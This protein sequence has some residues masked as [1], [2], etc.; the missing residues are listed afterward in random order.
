M[1][2]SVFSRPFDGLR[3]GERFESRGRTVT[4]AHVVAFAAF[5]GDWHPV[6]S[7]AVWAGSSEFGGRIA[8][9]LLV[10]SL[11]I[12]MLELD[13]AWVVALRRISKA[14]FKAPVRLGDTIHVEGSVVALRPVGRD[15]GLVDT[16]WRIVNQEGRAVAVFSAEVV[17]RGE[18]V[19]AGR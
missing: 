10:L 16:A 7:D 13:P 3:V 8:H 18:G 2:T 17:W 5:T 19:V 11:A 14:T 6:H 12:G 4:E 15:G 1:T 9:G